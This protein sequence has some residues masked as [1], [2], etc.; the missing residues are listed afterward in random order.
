[1]LLPRAD[2]TALGKQLDESPLGSL[3]FHFVADKHMTPLYCNDILVVSIRRQRHDSTHT[4]LLIARGEVELFDEG[5]LVVVSFQKRLRNLLANKLAF[6]LHV[7]SSLSACLILLPSIYW[8]GFLK[9]LTDLHEQTSKM[10]LALSV[11]HSPIVVAPSVDLHK[12]G[13]TRRN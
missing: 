2:D 13:I 10:I 8:F 6:N 11:A 4:D 3:Y 1:M 7:S 12:L 5:G 9:F